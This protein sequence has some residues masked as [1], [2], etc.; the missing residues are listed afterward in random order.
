MASNLPLA[1]QRH[2]RQTADS[3]V[4]LSD[5]PGDRKRC[6]RRPGENV[7]VSRAR[8][9]G[10]GARHRYRPWRRDSSGDA[11]Q[12]EDQRAPAPPGALP[13]HF[14]G[15]ASGSLARLGRTGNRNRL[16]RDGSIIETICNAGSD[17]WYR[18]RGESKNGTGAFRV[19]DNGIGI[20]FEN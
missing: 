4:A 8:T 20:A 19:K 1:D 13:R 2:V 10:D 14:Y 16:L 7:R 17:P 3:S 12:I 15:R 11:T 9:R 5:D 18:F 6:R